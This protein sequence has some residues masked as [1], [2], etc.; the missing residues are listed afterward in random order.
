ML[1]GVVVHLVQGGKEG[2]TGRVPAEQNTRHAS[3]NKGTPGLISLEKQSLK[4]G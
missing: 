1:P 2:F 3:S 4:S